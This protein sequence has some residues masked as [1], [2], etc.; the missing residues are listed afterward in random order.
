MY[1][2]QLYLFAAVLIAAAELVIWNGFSPK[3]FQTTFDPVQQDD[4]SIEP[5][6][7]E[8]GNLA[9][10]ER[11]TR[12]VRITNNK[13]RAI[14]LSQPRATC[15]CVRFDLEEPVSIQPGETAEIEFELVAPGVPG[16]ISKDLLFE[17]A[18]AKEPF[19][20]PVRAQAIA[21]SWADPPRHR[22][23]S[24]Q[25]DRGLIHLPSS[26]RIADV[27]ISDPENVTVTLGHATSTTQ[28]YRIEVTGQQA[29]EGYVAWMSE[30]EDCLATVDV[31]WKPPMVLVCQP[32]RVILDPGATE[33]ATTCD[34][35]VLS[36]PEH[37]AEVKAEP[38][39]PWA[40]VVSQEKCSSRTMKIKIELDRKK[41]PHR[42]QGDVLRV[43]DA[44]SEHATTFRVHI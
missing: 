40:R 17:F 25:V 3:T 38:L 30:E 12:I 19:R 15:G 34:I 1:S 9:L 20:I 23:T 21:S 43:Y 5:Q 31:S 44:Q 11:Q 33:L 10:M 36:D 27:I 24:G 7:I 13:R 2:T 4:I 16:P 6:E 8:F 39:V 35:T 28:A 41:T 18:T 26:K 22:L 42:F 32:K 37:V 14:Q 29:G